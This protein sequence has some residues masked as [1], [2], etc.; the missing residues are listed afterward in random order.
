MQ[1]RIG[2]YGGTFDPIHN[3]HLNVA[4]TLIEKFA[5]DAM[6]LIP[7]FVPPHKR[8]Q[9]I[10]SSYHRYAMAALATAGMSR[11]FLSTIELEAPSRPWTIETLGSLQQI[12]PQSQLFFVMGADSFADVT[13]W[14]EHERLLSEYHI[15]VAARPGHEMND[16]QA[17]DPAAHLSAQL[18][19]RVMDLRGA[20]LPQNERLATP[21]IWITDYV[22]FDVSASE[23]R[24]AV[25]AGHNVAHLVPAEVA[26][27]ISKYQLYR[28]G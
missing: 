10:T 18:R 25:G 4:S 24:A 12:F 22:A 2:V 21:H 27:Y 16:V 19:K 9:H 3:G 8:A 13:S 23:I 14:R 6:L 7:A 11:M 26:E 28:E 20:M 15:I 17:D 1:Q 5:L